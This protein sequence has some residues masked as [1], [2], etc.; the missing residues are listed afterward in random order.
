MYLVSSVTSS[1]LSCLKSSPL[2]LCCKKTEQ[3]WQIH[4]SRVTNTVHEERYH[5]GPW[6]RMIMWQVAMLLS[7]WYQLTQVSGA[8]GTLEASLEKRMGGLGINGP[9]TPPYS[10]VAGLNLQP[11]NTWLLTPP[12]SCRKMVLS[13]FLGGVAVFNS[14][15]APFFICRHHQHNTR[16]MPVLLSYLQSVIQRNVELWQWLW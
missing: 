9:I 8:F 4:R 13:L 3:S 16:Q 12:D 1:C 15:G 11:L 10:L 5:S 7:H 14:L 2:D 6:L